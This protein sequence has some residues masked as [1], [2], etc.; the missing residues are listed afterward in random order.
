MLG[1]GPREKER[2]VP[3]TEEAF[4]EARAQRVEHWLH[5]SPQRQDVLQA[6][7]LGLVQIASDRSIL[8]E[9]SR[10]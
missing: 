6:Q 2:T 4:M 9:G 5:T 8:R 10:V 7:P 3:G 1:V